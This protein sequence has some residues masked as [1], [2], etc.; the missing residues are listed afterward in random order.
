MM[1]DTAFDWPELDDI[2]GPCI[3]PGGPLLTE[4]ALKVCNLPTGSLVA[5][6]GCGAGGTLQYL[7]RTRR[8]QLVGVDDSVTLLAKA[9]TRLETAR[10]IQGRAEALPFEHDT[11]DALFCECVLSI[12]DDKSAALDE[13]ARVVKE[14]GFLV[15]SDIFSNTGHEKS[16]EM[17]RLLSQ[18]VIL[19]SLSRRGFTVLLWEVHDR[20]LKEFAVRMIFA[21]K[22]LPQLWGCGQG[23]NAG[24]NAG[25]GYYLLA[26]RKEV[27]DFEAVGSGIGGQL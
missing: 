26:A 15:L 18:E 6:I 23:K 5:D 3:R 14:G 8:F 10:L 27:A 16:G 11:F 20:L 25:L 22:S 2:A 24:K 17:D 19:D 4:R 1:I 21:G 13:F 9:A 12:I 7:E